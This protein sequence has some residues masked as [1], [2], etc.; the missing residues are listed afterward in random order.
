MALGHVIPGDII[1]D[2]KMSAESFSY[3]SF[4]SMNIIHS[5]NTSVLTRG[6]FII[7]A[8]NGA[9]TLACITGK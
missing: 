4:R 8:H 5:T 7:S 6:S 1:C 3:D 2:Q 9:N